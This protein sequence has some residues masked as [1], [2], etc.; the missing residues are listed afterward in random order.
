VNEQAGE[1]LLELPKARINKIEYKEL[2]DLL[3]LMRRINE[4]YRMLTRSCLTSKE[5]LLP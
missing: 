5:W 2:R 4:T 1:K 3:R